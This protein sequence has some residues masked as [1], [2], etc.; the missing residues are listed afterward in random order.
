[1]VGQ[2]ILL[3]LSFDNIFRI[4]LMISTCGYEA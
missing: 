4:I 2:D 1:M 3:K